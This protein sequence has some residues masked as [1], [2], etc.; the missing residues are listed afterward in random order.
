MA[1]ARLPD[2]ENLGPGRLRPTSEMPDRL[3]DAGV[4]ASIGGFRGGHL[5]AGETEVGSGH[6]G[7][8]S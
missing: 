1:A 5:A 4:H 2:R 6:R 7:E 8:E 3:P